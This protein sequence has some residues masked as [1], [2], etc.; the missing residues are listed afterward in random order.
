MDF[1]ATAAKGT[2]PALRDEL[3][4]LRFRGV[5][6]D[7]GGVHFAGPLEEGF[8]ACIELRTAV[9][10]L[11]ELAAFDAPD[12][13]ALYQGV[14]EV[15]WGPYLSPRHT[16]AVRASCRSSALTHT[17]F[18]AQRTKD[19][20]VD[21]L[22]RRLGARPSVDLEDP[23]VALFVHLVRDRATL[24]AD[25][26]GASLH[27]RGYRTHIGDAPLKETLAA[28]L[29][30]L[31]GWD[32]ARPLL[33]PMCGSGT[34]ALEA[35][36]W[37][38]DIAP[39]L[40]SPPFGFERWACHDPAAA[41]RAS[42]LRDAARAR[43]KPEGPPVFASDIDPRA[44]EIALGNARMAGVKLDVRAQPITALSAA[45]PPGHVLTNPPYGER[46]QGTQALYRDIAAAVSRLAGHRVAILAGTPE[47]ERAMARPPERSLTVYNGPIECRLLTYVIP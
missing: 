8:R 47:I 6:A 15:D 5:R 25:L 32:R 46:L 14:S 9:R 37:A 23:D 34:I 39:G 33:D 43:I 4:E 3:R 11:V 42:A 40:R 10:V 24:Y 45:T 30:R 41:Q 12:E 13:G 16:L 26:G 27:R 35:A 7:R 29:L 21:Q 2:E 36:L 1:F 18:I 44:V 38:R 31:S 19:A 20:I 17:Q 28:A 22:R